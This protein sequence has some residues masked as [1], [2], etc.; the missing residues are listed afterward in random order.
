MSQDLSEFILLKIKELTFE[1]VNVDTPLVSTKVLDSIIAV[2]LAVAIEEHCGIAIPFTEI[3]E[4]NFE[5]VEKIMAY[6]AT[7]N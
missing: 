5:T 6:L 3:T 2:D 1:S 4:E 7:K